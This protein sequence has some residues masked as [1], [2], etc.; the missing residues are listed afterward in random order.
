VDVSLNAHT[1]ETALGYEPRRQ[2]IEART[3]S[4]FDFAA[5]STHSQL[6][7]LPYAL[8]TTSLPF[9][10]LNVMTNADSTGSSDSRPIEKLT[11]GNYHT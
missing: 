3:T 9:H 1:E 6:T 2:L 4:V 5:A 11:H 7:T 8:T 10:V